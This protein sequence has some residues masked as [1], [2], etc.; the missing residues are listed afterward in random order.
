MIK[1]LILFS[2]IAIFT[3]PIT[4]QKKLTLEEAISIA[5]QRNSGLIKTQNS[6]S[7]A[8]HD[9]KSAYGDFL[10]NM[11]LSAGWSWQKK[12]YETNDSNPYESENQSRSYS[13]S[14]GGNWVLFNG[15]S[16]YS[17]L[18]GAKNALQSA[19]FNLDR[20][21][22]DVIYQTAESYYSILAAE[23]LIEV[24]KENLLFNQKFFETVDEKNKLGAV[25]IADVYK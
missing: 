17:N 25:P 22:E 19:E 15:L 21:K 14:A 10:P 4:A 23:A 13:L 3:I 11:S 6:L 24:R 1:K 5:L 12:K 16:N 7:G 20:I 2:I 8:E 18:N 9:L